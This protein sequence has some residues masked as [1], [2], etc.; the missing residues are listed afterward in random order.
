MLF[1]LVVLDL[2]TAV[3]TFTLTLVVPVVSVVASN[4]AIVWKLRRNQKESTIA[5]DSNQ[6]KDREITISLIFLSVLFILNMIAFA[7]C[8]FFRHLTKS[9]YRGI[10]KKLRNK[11]IHQNLAS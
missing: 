2:R 1:V 8:E 5:K 6:K 7:A 9:I 10:W 3:Y 11:N 4:V